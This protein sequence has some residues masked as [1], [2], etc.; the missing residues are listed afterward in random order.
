[1][2]EHYKRNASLREENVEMAKKMKAMI[3]QYETREQVSVKI[4]LN[5]TGN[6]GSLFESSLRKLVV[7]FFSM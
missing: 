2:D 5:G 1:M 7:H 6:L 3:D 4:S